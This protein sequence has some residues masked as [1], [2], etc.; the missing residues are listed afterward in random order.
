VDHV[1]E[2]DVLDLP[3]LDAGALERGLGGGGA[4]VGRRDILEALP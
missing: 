2:H 4:E 3:R 1:A